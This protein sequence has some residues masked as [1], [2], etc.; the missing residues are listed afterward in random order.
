MT[1]HLL[2]CAA[3]LVLSAAS[4][5]AGTL[6]FAGDST[7]DEHGG[8]QDRYG[9]WGDALRP[10]LADGCRIVKLERNYRSMAPIL[11]VANCV[12]KDVQHQFEKTLRPF[13]TGAAPK[14]R[15]YHVYD[16]RAQAE[17]ILRLVNTMRQNGIAYKD[18]AILY[19]SHYTSIDIQMALTRSRVP[20]RITSGVGVF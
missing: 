3:F 15:L 12:M 1:K 9:S 6:F 14:P 5:L 2:A 4:A 11:D 18:V 16:G 17:A 7:L 19:R 8:R 13:R 10:W 20:F